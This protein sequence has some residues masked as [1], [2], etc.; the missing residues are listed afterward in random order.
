M[1]A[2]DTLEMLEAAKAECLR[3]ERELV[4]VTTELVAV[5]AERDRARDVA[6]HLLDELPDTTAEMVDNVVC[7]H[8]GADIVPT[9]GPVSFV[10]VTTGRALCDPDSPAFSKWARP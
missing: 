8:C 9:A 1:G 6:A 7:R 3:L 10:H 4:K 2:F 5:T